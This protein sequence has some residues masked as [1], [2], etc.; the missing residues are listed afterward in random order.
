VVVLVVVMALLEWVVV[1]VVL[2]LVVVMAH[3]I[4]MLLQLPLEH[5]QLVVAVEEQQVLRER[6]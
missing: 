6:I 2:M 4:Q 1:L 3:N 5:M